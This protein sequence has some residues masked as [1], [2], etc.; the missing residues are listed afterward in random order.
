MT[1]KTTTVTSVPGIGEKRNSLGYRVV[2]RH[3]AKL[4]TENSKR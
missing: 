2:E 3:S 1:M 4:V